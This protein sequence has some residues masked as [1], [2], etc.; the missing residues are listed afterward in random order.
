MV[1]AVVVKN[2]EIVGEG[3]H[4]RAGEPHA[5]V[6]ALRDAGEA[7][8]GAVMYVT[9]E[10][11]RHQG[12]T[13]PCTRAIIEAGVSEVHAAMVDP[14]PKVAGKGI[15]ELRSAGIM[16]HCP[17]CEDASRRLNEAY[18]KHR[19]TG[20]P[21]VILKSAMSLDGRIATRTGDSKWITNERS[22][23]YSHRLRSR[24]D[25]ILVG[26]ATARTDD[27]QLTARLGRRV[28]RPIRVVI[29]ETGDLPDDLAMLCGDG[30]CLVACPP[31]AEAESL[32]KLERA[33]ARI[34][35]L[36]L[37]GGRASMADL[38]RQLGEMGCPSVMI[39]GGGEVAASALAERVVDKVVFFY[40][41]K[42]IG[43]REAVP[44][45]GGEGAAN[46]ASSIKLDRITLRR[47][48]EDF[49]VEGYVVR[50]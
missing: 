12:R 21:F 20:M 2:G 1:G 40:A 7:A 45:V 44:A 28:F 27:P 39:E 41:P 38:M 46:V 26:A 29:T 34:L 5:E 42:I 30:E 24:V 10:P 35:T 23:A 14:D 4:P 22:R 8:R 15:E 37:S 13:P 25:A 48:G 6:F 19:T 3:Y 9:L 47:F 16:V 32:R 33:G 49:V 31:S 18:I 43:G 11:C 36:S 17:L 50:E